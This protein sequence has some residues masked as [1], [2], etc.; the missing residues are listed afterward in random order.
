MLT[1]IKSNLYRCH[2]MIDDGE[3]SDVDY[4]SYLVLMVIGGPY[5]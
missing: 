1:A 2:E 5:A 4:D 3:K